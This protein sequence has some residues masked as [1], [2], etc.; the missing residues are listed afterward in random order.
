MEIHGVGLPD[1][2]LVGK[3]GGFSSKFVGFLPF[4][5]LKKLLLVVSWCLK[6]NVWIFAVNFTLFGDAQRNIISLSFIMHE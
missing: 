6:G 1:L 5:A 4:P 3:N 2:P